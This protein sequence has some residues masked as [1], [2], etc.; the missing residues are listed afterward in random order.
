MRKAAKETMEP[1][2]DELRWLIFNI[3]HEKP[4][5]PLMWTD[6]S[7][8]NLPMVGFCSGQYKIGNSFSISCNLIFSIYAKMPTIPRD[9]FDI[10]RHRLLAFSDGDGISDNSISLPNADLSYRRLPRLK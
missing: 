5:F 3:R 7:C 8:G 1:K 10:V 2:H 9:I 4:T 6:F